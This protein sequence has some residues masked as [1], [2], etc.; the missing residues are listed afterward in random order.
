MLCA[1]KVLVDAPDCLPRVCWS[2][3][4]SQAGPGFVSIACQN[5]HTTPCNEFPPVLTAL[6]LS[7]LH[8][9]LSNS[10]PRQRRA[11]MIP[12]LPACQRPRFVT[13]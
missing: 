4:A 8:P 11:A 5:T 7:H 12:T 1:V 6:L 3:P 9:L 2:C 13:L 10:T